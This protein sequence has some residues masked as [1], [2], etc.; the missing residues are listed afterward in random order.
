MKEHRVLALPAIRQANHAPNEGSD[1]DLTGYSM[2]TP[3]HAPMKGATL[4]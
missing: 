2:D 1:T 3:I 4:P